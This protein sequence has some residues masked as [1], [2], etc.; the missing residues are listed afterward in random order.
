MP[1]NELRYGKVNIFDQWFISFKDNVFI[2]FL[3]FK[4]IITNLVVLPHMFLRIVFFFLDYWIYVGSYSKLNLLIW[5]Y[6]WV[7]KKK[8]KYIDLVNISMVT[9]KFL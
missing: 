2:I 9:F 7:S 8:K 6:D 1:L 5:K 3:T 4:I